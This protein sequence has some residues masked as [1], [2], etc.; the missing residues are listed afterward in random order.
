MS[1]HTK[2]SGRQK[3]PAKQSVVVE[4]SGLVG[5]RIVRAGSD[6]RLELR[7]SLSLS[8]DIFSR[9]VNVSPRAIADVESGRKKVPKLQRPY[10]EVRRVYD[11]L[12]EVVSPETLGEWFVTPNAAFGDLKPIEVI[13][14][15]E[16]DRLWEMVYRLQSGMPG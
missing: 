1:T 10:N 2:K 15:G 13:E 11:A 3:S 6:S 7:R 5:V 9:L 12:S 14:R 16:I 4:S 8:R